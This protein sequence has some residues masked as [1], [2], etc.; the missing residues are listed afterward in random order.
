MVHHDVE[1]RQI[2]SLWLNV[3]IFFQMPVYATGI[4]ENEAPFSFGSTMPPL[5]FHWSISNSEVAQLQP[6]F[7]KVVLNIFLDSFINEINI[8]INLS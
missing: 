3:I 2:N 8:Q 6:I 7:H 5:A 1:M 4:H